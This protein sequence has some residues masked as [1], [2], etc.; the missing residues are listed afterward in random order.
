M[1]A[2]EPKPMQLIIRTMTM[3]PPR[4]MTPMGRVAAALCRLLP[5]PPLLLLLLLV[6][7]GVSGNIVNEPDP[8]AGT[9]YPSEHGNYLCLRRFG[10]ERASDSYPLP[11]RAP[12]ED[13]QVSIR[14]LGRRAAPFPPFLI[15]H[16]VPALV[17]P[18]ILVLTTLCVL[19]AVAVRAEVRHHRLVARPCN[20][21][22]YSSTY[23]AMGFADVR[24]GTQKRRGVFGYPPDH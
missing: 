8:L 20:T 17:Y 4:R 2:F 16:R 6:A 12:R 18:K 13:W 3:P 22:G 1:H 14:I 15:S 19:A 10:R 7:P 5:P 11:C 23:L 24:A 21:K 9:G